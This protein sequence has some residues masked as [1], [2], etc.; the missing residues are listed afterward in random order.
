MFPYQWFKDFFSPCIN[1][2][3]GNFLHILTEKRGESID[4]TTL[5]FYT[6]SAKIYDLLTRSL[7]EL[8]G[9]HLLEPFFSIHMFS[10]MQQCSEAS[11]LYKKVFIFIC[12][13]SCLINSDF[14]Q[15]PKALS[16]QSCSL[17]MFFTSRNFVPKCSACYISSEIAV[18]TCRPCTQVHTSSSN[19]AQNHVHF[20]MSESCPCLCRRCQ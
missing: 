11:N 14:I 8:R 7:C 15:G 3:S 17:Y 13:L 18:S 10:Y 1:G 6:F 12:R 4:K 19:A 16:N 5:R 2:R 20:K 9:E